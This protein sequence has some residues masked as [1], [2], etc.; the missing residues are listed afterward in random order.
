MTIGKKI[1]AGFVAPLVILLGIAGI[2]CWTTYRLIDTA[3]WVD[4]THHVLE[5]LEAL[6]FDLS[7]GDVNAGQGALSNVEGLTSDN[8]AQ[9]DRLKKLRSLL[10]DLAKAPTNSDEYKKG[11]DTITPLI[12]DMENSKDRGERPLLRSGMWRPTQP[13]C[14]RTGRSA[15]R[16]SSPAWSW[17]S[18]PSS[19]C[20]P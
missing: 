17:S 8:A 3:Y 2:A 20:D 14:S 4:H 18:S 6:R 7:N 10:S 15:P 9:Q 16:P 12:D 11:L 13:P 19:W 1:V 5:N